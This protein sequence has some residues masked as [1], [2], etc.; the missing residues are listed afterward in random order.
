MISKKAALL[1]AL[2]VGIFL[3]IAVYALDGI[4]EYPMPDCE[5]TR[6]LE[7]ASPPM[8][9]YDVVEL[10]ARMVELDLYPGPVTGI[11][12]SRLAQAVQEFQ[13]SMGL[14]ATGVV[15]PETWLALSG[16]EYGDR[17]AIAT[18]RPKGKINLRIDVASRTLTVYSDGEVYK[19]YPVGVG[20]PSTPSPIGEWKVTNKS[21]NWGGGFGTRWL[22]LNVP[23]G[24][25]GIHGTNKPWSI[26]RNESHGCIR[27]HNRDVEELYSWIPVGTQVDI[28]GDISYVN[29]RNWLEPG[30]TGKDVVKFQL[31]L[32]EAGFDPDRADGR[33]G[34]RTIDAVK[35]LQDHYGLPVTGRTGPDELILLRVR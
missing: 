20:K 16:E 10:E 6:L 8:A 7:L 19:R 3:R 34:Q 4:E 30:V 9:G 32:R 21:T 13:G 15:G 27:M 35:S 23:W 28:V 12:D 17:A 22:G 14:A 25:Y 18:P 2:L 24:I 26:G 11:Y 29:I 1:L 5:T 33:Y 31:L